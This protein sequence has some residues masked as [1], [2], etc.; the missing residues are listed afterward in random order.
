M[1]FLK[2]FAGIE[3][4]AFTTLYVVIANI[5]VRYDHGLSGHVSDNPE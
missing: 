1:D 5:I 4:V 3:I 2:F